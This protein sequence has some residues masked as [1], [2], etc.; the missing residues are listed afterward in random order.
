MMSGTLTHWGWVMHV[1]WCQKQVSRA[2]MNNNIPQNTVACDYLSMLKIPASG[3]LDMQSYE[4]LNYA[5]IGSD[6]SL[7]PVR[8][9]AIIQI[10]ADL[11]SF[12]PLETNFSEILI[13]LHEFSFKKMPLKMSSA[14]WWQKQTVS[15]VSAS[16]KNNHICFWTFC[17]K[18][19]MS[20]V[21]VLDKSDYVIA[22]FQYDVMDSSIGFNLF[23]TQSWI[24]L[25]LFNDDMSYRTSMG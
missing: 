24:E 7:A 10:N 13:K 3:S 4:S 2:W 12:G 25:Q 8:R 19:T 22:K 6:N 11:M 20:L 21:N 18:M 23:L 9:Q 15:V 17:T 5:N 14:K 16:D 1:Y